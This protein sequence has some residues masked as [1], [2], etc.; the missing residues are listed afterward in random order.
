M[1]LKESIDGLRIPPPE[2]AFVDLIKI[3]VERR[4]PV[5]LEYEIVPFIPQLAENW[6]KVRRLAAEEGVADYLEAI[7]SYV[8]KVAARS[9]F[10]LAMPTPNPQGGKALKTLSFAGGRADE[11]SVETGSET[12]IVIEADQEAVKGVLSNL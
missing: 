10:G 12:G 1:P 6:E 9:G 3:A 11:V 7:L 4:R 5:S 2:V 8:V